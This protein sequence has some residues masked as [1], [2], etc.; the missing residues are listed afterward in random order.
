MTDWPI[1]DFDQ[2]PKAILN[3]RGPKLSC[4]VPQGM[5]LCFFK[6]VLD[7]LAAEGKLEQVGHCASEMGAHPIYRMHQ[8]GHDLLVMHPGVGAPLAAGLL[9]EIISLR[10]RRF[11]VC[12]GCGVLEAEIAAGH[13]MVVES[14]VRDEGTSYHYLPPGREV[15]AHPAGIQVIEAVLQERGIDFRRV[16]TW[17]TDGI[18]RETEKRRALRMAEGCAVVEMEAAAFLAVAQFRGVVLGQLLYG[19]DLVVPEGW[20]DRGWDKRHSDRR[21]LFDLAVDACLR[22]VQMEVV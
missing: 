8:A 16:K 14:A 9:D 4:P 18:Y 11:I 7:G 10:V 6:E 17:T 22:L 20:D 13:P 1:L 12:G 21:L 3:P 2:A 5:V 15:A 19:G